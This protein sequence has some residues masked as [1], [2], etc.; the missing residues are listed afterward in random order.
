MITKLDERGKPQ[1]G[2]IFTGLGVM[3]TIVVVIGGMAYMPI[4]QAQMRLDRDIIELR[5][6]TLGVSSFNEFKAT[7]ENNRIVS[8]TE[9]NEKFGNANA[10]VDSVET[11]LVPR[12]ELDRVFLSYD[13]QLREKQRQLDEI[14][15][16]QAGIY[17]A[18]DAMMDM[19]DRIDRLEARRGV[20]GPPQ[21]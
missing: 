12:D 20:A 21:P 15:A 3:V 4:Q 7:Y 18:R 13:E 17:G 8:R 10:R 14:K 11:R 9:N 1:W 2:I 5:A 16:Q 19:R 6:G